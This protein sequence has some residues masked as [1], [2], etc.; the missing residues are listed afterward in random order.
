MYAVIR[1]KVPYSISKHQAPFWLKLNARWG[2]YNSSV[3][4]LVSDLRREDKCM[5]N[6]SILYLQT[7]HPWKTKCFQEIK[8]SLVFIF[9]INKIKVLDQ[10]TAEVPF[11]CKHS[12]ILWF[13][14]LLDS[15]GKKIHIYISS[16]YINTDSSDETWKQLTHLSW[17]NCQRGRAKRLHVVYYGINEDHNECKNL[18]MIN[19]FKTCHLSQHEFSQEVQ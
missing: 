14:I 5:D 16:S 11:K 7:A 8:P 2:S 18:K 3:L 15:R 1:Y 13:W 6:N 10:I 9:L 19:S 4:P 12:M 17:K